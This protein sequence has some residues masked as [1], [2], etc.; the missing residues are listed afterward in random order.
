MC[1]YNLSIENS[2]NQLQESSSNE[3]F[4]VGHPSWDCSPANSLNFGV[5]MELEASELPKGPVLG[6]D[7]NIHIRLAGS[8]P[9][10][11]VGSYNPPLLGARCP[12]R[13]T[14]IMRLL[15]CELA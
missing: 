14:P 3:N 12:R 7:E 11:D 10:S 5:L 4:P 13:H 1:E 9:L 15:S 6:R 8:S 2:K